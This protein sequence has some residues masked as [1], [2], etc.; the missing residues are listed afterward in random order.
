MSKMVMKYFNLVE[1]NNESLYKIDYDLGT[2]YVCFDKTKH[3]YTVT[4]DRPY[5]ATDEIS[6]VKPITQ[7]IKR[8]STLPQGVVIGLG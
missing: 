5:S 7:A 2:M 1:N 8:Q 6:I 4:G 3:K